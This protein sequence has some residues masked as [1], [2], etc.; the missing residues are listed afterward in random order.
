MYIFKSEDFKKN[1]KF[2][3]EFFRLVEE[4]LKLY[5]HDYISNTN[6]SSLEIFS[7]E[8]GE[9]LYKETNYVE[10]VEFSG[11]IVEKIFDNLPKEIKNLYQED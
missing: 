3:D 4:E 7:L 9:I 1:K 5:P 2:F 10:Y 11:K 8:T 6:P